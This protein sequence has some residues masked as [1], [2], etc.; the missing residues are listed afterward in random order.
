[1]DKAFI[2]KVLFVFAVAG[3]IFLAWRL[4]DVFLL[5]FGAVIVAVLLR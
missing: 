1:M 4:I 2:R 3:L 5:A